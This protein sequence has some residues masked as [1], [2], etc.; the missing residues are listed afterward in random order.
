MTTKQDKKR[1]YL[2]RKIK[3]WLKVNAREKTVYLPYNYK[4]TGKALFYYK[5]LQNIGYST[6]LEIV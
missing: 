6:Q 3:K 1:Y 5:Q 2:H 4:P